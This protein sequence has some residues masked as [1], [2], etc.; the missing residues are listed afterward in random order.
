MLRTP[1]YGN[2]FRFVANTVQHRTVDGDLRT[3]RGSRPYWE[4]FSV[5]FKALNLE[6]KDAFVDF[7][8][9]SRGEIIR[10]LDFENRVWE[11]VIVSEVIKVVTGRGD[12]NYETSFDFEGKVLDVLLTWPDDFSLVQGTN[13]LRYYKRVAHVLTELVVDSGSWWDGAV[14]ALPNISISGTLHPADISKANLRWTS[15]R[16]IAN[17]RVSGRISNLNGL[18]ST[19]AHFA[20]QQNGVVKYETDV[21]LDDDFNFSFDIPLGYGDNIDFI[22]DSGDGDSIEDQ[23]DLE[24]TIAAI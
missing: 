19:G 12:C 8:T 6:Q 3:Y 1:E 16:T 5:E 24:F 4:S 17:V 20:I 18:G 13:N 14:D 22:A 11:G 15:S 21:N 9:N 2:Q 10:L 7:V 23:L